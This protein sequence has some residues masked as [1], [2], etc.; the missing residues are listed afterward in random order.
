MYNKVTKKIQECL[1]FDFLEDQENQKGKGPDWM[2]DL[3]ILTPSMNYVP[4]R[5]ENQ[6]VHK[7]EDSHY[8]VHGVNVRPEDVPDEEPITIE[9]DKS[10]V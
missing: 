8:I 5:E 2:F 1:H 10:T 9:K 7:E 4:V 3:D 6:V